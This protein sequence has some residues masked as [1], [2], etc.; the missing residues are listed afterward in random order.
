MD[1]GHHCL[2]HG[3][4]PSRVDRRRARPRLT[5]WRTVASGTPRRRDRSGVGLVVQ[6]ARTNR[7]ALVVGQR[8]EREKQRVGC[9]LGVGER[10]DAFHRRVAERDLLDA[11][12]VTGAVL[13]SSPSPRAMKEM[14]GDTQQP[15]NRALALVTKAAG[16]HDRGRKRLRCQVRHQ[17]TIRGP[18]GQET[19]HDRLVTHIELRER[20]HV[21]QR[22]PT[23]QLP[24]SP[25][26]LNAHH[27]RPLQ[28]TQHRLTTRSRKATSS[29]RDWPP[30]P[31]PCA[32]AWRRRP[33]LAEAGRPR[34]TPPPDATTPNQ[35]ASAKATST[36]GS[37]EGSSSRIAESRRSRSVC[38]RAW[39]RAS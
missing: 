27:T 8:G 16:A 31:R 19:R 5:R 38:V 39:S 9:V 7:V 4:R 17:L 13:G 21:T 33:L 14:S 20:P 37:H 23:Q 32:T 22:H 30:T 28:R 15:A 3:I 26:V 18:A 10:F 35:T 29:R 11:E 34:S 24:I 12:P 25:G 6:D 2:R 36:T 1:F